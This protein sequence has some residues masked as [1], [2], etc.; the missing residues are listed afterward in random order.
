MHVNYELKI[1]AADDT[2][3]SSAARWL[4]K[5]EQSDSEARHRTRKLTQPRKVDGARA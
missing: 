5:A 3:Y 4:A 1:T 2:A